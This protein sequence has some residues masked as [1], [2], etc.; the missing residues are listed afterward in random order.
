MRFSSHNVALGVLVAF[1]AL[2]TLIALSQQFP[3]LA[4]YGGPLSSGISKLP[5][6]L[7]S[8][9]GFYVD[10]SFQFAT[11][12]WLIVGGAVYWRGHVK[13][14]WRRKG[15]ERDVFKLFL[16]MRGSRTRLAMLESLDFPKDRLQ[17]AKELDC[18]WNVAD[19]NIRV[20]LDH[21][22][23]CEK[24]AYGNVKFYELSPSGRDLLELMKRFREVQ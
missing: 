5:S 13:S 4:G 23:V 18:D 22:L 12:G 20:L 2:S 16:Q 1:S 3:I 14:T 7:I 6:P 21:R 19:R 11:G 9:I 10:N 24:K 8:G 17:L 15:F